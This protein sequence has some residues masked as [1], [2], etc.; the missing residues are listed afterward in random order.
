MW[1]TNIFAHYSKI[2]QASLKVYYTSETSEQENQSISRA[3]KCFK[4]AQNSKIIIS[5]KKPSK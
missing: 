5:I 4:M 2:Y 3:G 1:E